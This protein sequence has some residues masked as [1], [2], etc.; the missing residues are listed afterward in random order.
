MKR[1]EYI[2]Q[3]MRRNSD[4]RVSD[5]KTDAI[6]IVKLRER[7]NAKLDAPARGREFHGIAQQ[8]Q[9]DLAKRP[10]ISVHSRRRGFRIHGELQLSAP[11]ALADQVADMRQ[12]LP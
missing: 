6:V 4:S 11:S 12:Q 1:F 2:L 3:F 10:A 8:I 5:A 9:Q 7:L